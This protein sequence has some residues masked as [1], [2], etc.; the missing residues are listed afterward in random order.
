MRRFTRNPVCGTNS[1]TT[2]SWALTFARTTTCCVFGPDRGGGSP[3]D[4]YPD[5]YPPRKVEVR[6]PPCLTAPHGMTFTRERGALRCTEAKRARGIN[7]T[8]RTY[9]TMP[10]RGPC[11]ITVVGVGPCGPSIQ[12]QD[13]CVGDAPRVIESMFAILT[14]CFRER[15]PRRRPSD[16]PPLASSVC[17]ISAPTSNADARIGCC[18]GSA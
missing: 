16:C 18:R 13:G 14:G 4:P 17:A 8:H 2:T 5:P 9:S 15:L 3:K 7:S 11:R 10:R 1:H 12:T 6:A